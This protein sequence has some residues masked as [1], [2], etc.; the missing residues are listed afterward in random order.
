MLFRSYV[1]ENDTKGRISFFHKSFYDYYLSLYFYNKLKESI[2]D[3]SPDLFLEKLAERRLEPD[4]IEF[5]S[6][7]KEN[8]E[9][10]IEDSK[11]KLI[12]DR[13]EE[14]E[15]M[16]IDTMDR[17]DIKGNAETM[18]YERCNNIFAN[19]LNILFCFDIAQIF[20]ELIFTKKLM[21]KFSCS[22]LRISNDLE[23]VDLSNCDFQRADF[24]GAKL[25][26]TDFS[27]ANLNGANLREADFS[28]SNLIGANLREA[29]LIEAK[30][31]SADLSEANL[32]EANLRGANLSRADFRK[33]DF[34]GAK[35]REAKFIKANLSEAYLIKADFRG[36]NLRGADLSEADFNEADQIG[37]ASC[38]ERV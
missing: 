28:E 8:D 33:A 13:I 16:G 24:S 22:N 20:N 34:R 18:K 5:I 35:L 14:S 25:S 27:G 1:K 9:H 2:K 37:R 21:G 15:C 23:K 6:E 10:S 4:I 12:L 19:S 31:N 30:F 32:S 29:K 26:G 36:A 17:A 11:L 7:L 38:R 3:K